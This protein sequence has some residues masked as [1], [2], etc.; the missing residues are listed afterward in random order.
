MEGKEDE[1]R[2]WMLGMGIVALGLIL[3]LSGGAT[4]AGYYGEKRSEKFDSR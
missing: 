1:S 2:G 3:I 4:S